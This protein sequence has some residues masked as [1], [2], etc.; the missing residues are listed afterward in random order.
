MCCVLYP[1]ENKINFGDAGTMKKLFRKIKRS[2]AV[3][4]IRFFF[5][6][7]FN[8]NV[9]PQNGLTRWQLFKAD[10]AFIWR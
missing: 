5:N 2:R 3:W 9:Q 4:T 6:D 7:L 10:Y 1:Q 8:P